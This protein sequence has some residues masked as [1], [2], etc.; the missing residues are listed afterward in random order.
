MDQTLN[1]KQNGISH[2][3]LSHSHIPLH[4]HHEIST[5]LHTV[6]L[7]TSS[8]CM[9]PIF[10]S[11]KC[12]TPHEA[13]A[14]PK[15][16]QHGNSTVSHTYQHFFSFSFLDHIHITAGSPWVLYPPPPPPKK[17]TQQQHNNNPFCLLS[18]VQWKWKHCSLQF[19]IWLVLQV[20]ELT[21][22]PY[23][24]WNIW[25][26]YIQSSSH[27]WPI[28]VFHHRLSTLLQLGTFSIKTLWGF[29]AEDTV[30]YISV[31]NSSLLQ[32]QS[33]LIHNINYYYWM[34]L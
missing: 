2:Q 4:H 10:L 16:K 11:N 18:T 34:L 20:N 9:F 27:A 14:N 22:M 32:L 12:M 15:G 7:C 28:Q 24:K 17:N 13:W 33:T 29:E 25:H 21:S 6:S 5:L 19:S 8:T 3:W 1:H 26:V 23:S 31:F 30:A